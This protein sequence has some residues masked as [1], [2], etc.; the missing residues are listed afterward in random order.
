MQILLSCIECEFE[1]WGRTDSEMMNKITMWN[2]V[3]K[4]HAGTADHLMKMYQ[5]LPN[6]LYTTH[7]MQ[8]A[9]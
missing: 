3:R 7:P 8:A 2:H 1:D 9:Q 5:T 4:S 6:N